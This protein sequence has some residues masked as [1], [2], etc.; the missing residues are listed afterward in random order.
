MFYMNLFKE[1]IP[2]RPFLD[3][4]EFDKITEVEKRWVERLFSEEVYSVIM[5]M[6]GDKSPGPDGFTISFF[7]K[8]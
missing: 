5:N 3:G 8:C 1:E 6:K 2:L 4:M 7:Q